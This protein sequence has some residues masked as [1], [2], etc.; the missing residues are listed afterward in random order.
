MRILYVT[1]FWSGLKDILLENKAE[2][3]GMPAFIKP[4][5]HLLEHSH[6]IDLLIASDKNSTITLPRE[7]WLGKC[8]VRTFRFQTK[9]T[10]TRATSYLSATATVTKTLV[11]RKY[12]FVY[13]QGSSGTVANIPALLLNIKA[14]QRLYGTFLAEKSGKQSLLKTLLQHPLEALALILPKAFLLITNDGTKGDILHKN[15]G[16]SLYSFHFLLNGVDLPPISRES[17]T[18]RG[19]QI[20]FY[21]ARLERWKR[22]DIA[23]EI[24]SKLHHI[25]HLKFRLVC[26]GHI[27]DKSW[28]TEL[29]EKAEN[30][31]VAPYFTHHERLNK[32]EMIQ[33][34]SSSFA[35]LSLY[36][37]SNLGNVAIEALATGALLMARNDGSLNSLVAN[38]KSA[39]LIM[40]ADQGAH[41]IARLYEAPQERLKLMKS[42]KE[43]AQKV[44][45]PWSTRCRTEEAIIKSSG[46]CTI[47]II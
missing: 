39:I 7:H 6:S 14:G 27:Y 31:G 2:A 20:L 29:L 13:M 21:P 42:A 35:T 9:G 11:K 23:L 40:N 43:V 30:L 22:Q 44:F 45:K 15:I 41:E 3:S 12:D 19:E 4:L 10:L 18:P 24:L 33:T 28:H 17:K 1:A 34:Y 38:K 47:N 8:K 32:E 26:A 16:N 46:S 5:K 37:L 25:H 36:D